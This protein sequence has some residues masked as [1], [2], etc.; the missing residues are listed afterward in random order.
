MPPE[1][2][3]DGKVALVTGAASGVGRATAELLAA[4]GAAVACLDRL[5]DDVEELAAAITASGGEA[6]GVECDLRDPAAIEAALTRSLAWRPR[7]DVLAHVAGLGLRR[8]AE[9]T[10]PD[11]WE[12]VIDVN[13]RAPFLLTRA[14][15]APLVEAK[16]AVVAVS[17]LAGLAGWPYS[18][19]YAASKGGLV[20]MMRSFALELGPR[21]VRVNL[22]CPGGIETPLLDTLDEIV[23]PDPA[24]AKRGRGLDDSLAAPAEV[25][26]TIAFL[27]SADA[28]HVNGTTLTVDGGATA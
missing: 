8:R 25:A 14:A 19:V 13:L 10:S 27:A 24:A 3:F 20:T 26:A 28:A 21:G 18:T 1:G 11:D 22:V 17:S 6:L 9:D 23:D 15:I 16:G 12:R 5:G 2:S 7:L 4:R